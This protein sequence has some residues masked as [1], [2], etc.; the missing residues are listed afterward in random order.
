MV[1]TLKMSIVEVI[2]QETM[3]LK[4]I[5]PNC[6]LI[7]SSSVDIR[8]DAPFV[9]ESRKSSLGCAFN[10]SPALVSLFVNDVSSNI[11]ENYLSWRVYII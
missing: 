10:V 5:R 8:Y 4:E 3:N 1:L 9:R 7:L 11:M 6:C 2:V